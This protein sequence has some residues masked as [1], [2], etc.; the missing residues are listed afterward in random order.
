MHSAPF[1]AI[2]NIFPQKPHVAMAIFL[3]TFDDRP[4][5]SETDTQACT[6]KQKGLSLPAIL[7]RTAILADT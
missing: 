7:V 5:S 2:F 6:F 1:M 3:A 4:P